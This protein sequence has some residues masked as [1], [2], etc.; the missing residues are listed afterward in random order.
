MKQDKIRQ[1]LKTS[2]ELKHIK[3]ELSGALFF[4][5]LLVVID[6]IAG[7]DLRYFALVFGMLLFYVLFYLWRIFRIFQKVEHYTLCQTV[8][9]EPH[10]HGRKG[11]SVYFTADIRNSGGIRLSVNTHS[12]RLRDVAHCINQ[13]VTIAYNEETGMV[14]FIG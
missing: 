9:S 1:A 10:I 3:R 13:T 8:L 12:F 14:V 4:V 7:R 5:L 11:R 6:F 2:L